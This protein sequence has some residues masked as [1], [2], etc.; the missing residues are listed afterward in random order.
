MITQKTKNKII[1]GFNKIFR[2]DPIWNSTGRPPHRQIA[3]FKDTQNVLEQHSYKPANFG[4][5]LI[6]LQNPVDFT[7][8]EIIAIY[9]SLNANMQSSQINCTNL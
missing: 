3:D 4:A 9:A 6:F 5:L 7:V 1:E 8:V 2:N